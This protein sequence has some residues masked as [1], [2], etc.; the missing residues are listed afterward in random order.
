MSPKF[1]LIPT[2]MILASLA[3]CASQ[4]GAPNYSVQRVDPEQVVDVDYR[5]TDDDARSVYRGMVNDAL[6][7]PWIDNWK[8]ENGGKRPIVIIGTVKNETNDYID[9]K[10]FTK[11][12]EEEFINSGRVRVVSERDQRGELRDERLAGQEF[13]RPE[14]IKKVANELGADFMVLGRVGDLKQTSGNGGVIVNYYQVNLEIVDIESN[15]KVWI[16]TEEVKKIARRR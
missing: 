6:S 8:S 5:F 11:R 14:T 15:E 3:G 12:L 10:M 9:T 1:T 2:A 7:K 16:Q 13:N 4:G